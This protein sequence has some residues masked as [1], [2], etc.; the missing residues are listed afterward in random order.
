[1]ASKEN[2]LNTHD[3]AFDLTGLPPGLE[4]ISNLCR[5]LSANA[6][7]NVGIG[8]C[9]ARLMESEWAGRLDG[10]LA[11]DSESDGYLM[12]KTLGI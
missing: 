4:E 12:N 3:W 1:M 6:Y 8:F 9:K 5:I 7:G 2:L 11:R 10:R